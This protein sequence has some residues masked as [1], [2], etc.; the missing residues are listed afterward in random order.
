MRAYT[1]V[2]QASTH[3]TED[4]AA[5]CVDNHMNGAVS[6]CLM[7][8]QDALEDIHQ[9]PDADSES[10]LR[11]LRKLDSMRATPGDAD[12]SMTNLAHSLKREFSFLPGVL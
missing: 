3:Y 11:K 12:L 1:H 7:L 6:C 8:V 4:H 2:H 5:T 10:R 9:S